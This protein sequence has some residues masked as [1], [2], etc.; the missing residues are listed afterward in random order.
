M[1]RSDD[2][3]LGDAQRRPSQEA[4]PGSL[5]SFGSG[6]SGGGSGQYPRWLVVRLLGA[7]YG[8][9]CSS[10]CIR[11]ATACSSPDDASF[12]TSVVRRCNA[13]ACRSKL[14]RVPEHGASTG[15][16]GTGGAGQFDGFGPVK[17]VG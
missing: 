16:P 10:L 3:L 11:W 5:Q 6:A 15:W 1:L 7:R 9:L 17:Q 13:G 4:A 2:Q 8:L 14:G 12:A